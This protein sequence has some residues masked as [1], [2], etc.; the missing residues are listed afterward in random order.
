[1][2]A[3]ALEIFLHDPVHFDLFTKARLNENVLVLRR[4]MKQ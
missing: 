2:S 3:S 1:M 4:A